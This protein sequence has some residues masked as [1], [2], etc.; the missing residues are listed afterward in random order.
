MFTSTSLQNL[1]TKKPIY[2]GVLPGD[3][4][5]DISTFVVDVRK[6]SGTGTSIAAV[7]GGQV[8]L[9]LPYNATTKAFQP[10]ANALIQSGDV[11][12]GEKVKAAYATVAKR[13]QTV[14][15]RVTGFVGNAY[16]EPSDLH[17]VAVASI[18]LPSTSTSCLHGPS[19][20]WAAGGAATSCCPFG[21][22]KR[23]CVKNARCPLIEEN[24]K[25]KTSPSYDAAYP[26]PF[27]GHDSPKQIAMKD[28]CCASTANGAQ[29]CNP[30]NSYWI[31]YGVRSSHCILG[32]LVA[33]SFLAE[34]TD[35]DVALV[36]GG[37]L[38]SDL[39][40]DQMVTV[41]DVLKILPFKNAMAT[42]SLKGAFLLDML[43][44][45][46]SNFDPSNPNGK[47]LQ[48]AGIRAIFNPVPLPGKDNLVSAEVFR[49]GN[50]RWETIEGKAVY[51]LATS[52]Y[53]L[54]K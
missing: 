20:P 39:K 52:D 45:A 25:G 42:A 47:F 38:R 32:A 7:G 54:G 2:V 34:C 53:V 5:R 23:N 28:Y 19:G 41:G 11:S 10:N 4:G 9:S 6:S 46:Y 15:T 51:K 35:C 14:L 21:D 27:F 43:R 40:K 44:H 17:T 1:I 22:G 37:A 36:N 24:F 31:Q 3:Y 33:N 16:P 12:T 50:G 26:V 48:L 49:K 13:L 8:E 18:S 30:A 29:V